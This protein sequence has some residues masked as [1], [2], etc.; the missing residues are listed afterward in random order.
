MATNGFSDRFMPAPLRYSFGISASLGLLTIVMLGI[1][2]CALHQPPSQD[3]ATIE[4]RAPPGQPASGP[5]GKDYPHAKV[6]YIS[7]DE[8][9][10]GFALFLPDEPLPASADVVVFLHGLAQV[11]PKM[12]G[13]WIE[14]LVRKG[15]I[16][17]YPRYEK[18]TPPGEFETNAV[19]GIR[20]ALAE[21]Q[22]RCD[23]GSPCV[24]PRLDH[25]AVIGHS[26]GAALA[27]N[28]AVRAQALGLPKVQALMVNQGWYGSDIALPQGYGEMP[29]DTKMLILVGE[30]DIVVG[31]IFARRLW[32]ET[33]VNAP[34]KNL[35]THRVDAYNLFAPI[36]AGH[37]EPLSLQD[38]YDNGAFTALIGIALPLTHTNAVDFYCYW[39][40]SE[41]LL[42]CAFE[43]RNCET[44]FGNT[45]QQRFMGK[46]GDGRPVLELQVTTP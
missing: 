3:Y 37:D 33:K 32:R 7:K 36:N 23:A 14:H 46:W 29:A 2:G 25:F 24:R 11:N 44:A 40:L 9:A 15:N 19:T 12:Y 41:A 20:G 34:F 31:N 39:K 5:G 42:S 16:V 26:Y 21:L 22:A 18:L 30:A 6:T 43:N 28:L 8:N 38:D 35:V 17:I 10:D 4:Q 45:P 27:A 13:G 1:S